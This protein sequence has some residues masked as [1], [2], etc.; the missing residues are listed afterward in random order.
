MPRARESSNP[1]KTKALQK[2]QLLDF[3]V[4]LDK[5]VDPSKCQRGVDDVD[6]E[7]TGVQ[8]TG[9]QAV[10]SDARHKRQSSFTRS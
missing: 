6:D 9:I 3:G 2:R 4:S 8:R 1:M 5:P 7:A 10:R